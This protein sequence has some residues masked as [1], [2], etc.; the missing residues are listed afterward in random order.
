MLGAVLC[1]QFGQAVGKSLFDTVGPPGVV[2]LRLGMA[3]ALLL[4]LHRPRLPRDRSE[5]RLVLG[6]GTAIAGMNLIYPA[7]SRLPLGLASSLQLLGPVALALLTSRRAREAGCAL[8]AGC[9]VWLFHSHGAT[10]FPPAGVLLALAS[11]ASMALYL[12]LSS[13]A[14][15]RSADGGPLALA[16]AWAAVLTVP[17]GV[18]D[19]GGAL[20][21]PEVLLTGLAVAVLS[22]VLPYSLELAALRRLPTGTVGVLTSLEPAVAGVAG[23]VV[24]GEHLL[25]VQW[26]ALGC[27]STASAGM[28]VRRRPPGGAPGSARA[29]SYGRGRAYGHGLRGR[30]YA[31][32]RTVTPRSPADRA[33]PPPARPGSR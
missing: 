13:R 22:A 9:G 17:L 23:T 11:G 12:V 16:V 7:M 21:A 18:A 4:L 2:A 26:L 25:P 28:V 33:E 1:T 27:V 15:A 6:F 14:G 29:G 24:L 3:A 19:S 32:W 10:A 5:L 30:A 31:R 8:L 20:L